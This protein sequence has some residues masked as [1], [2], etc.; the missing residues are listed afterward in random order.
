MNASATTAHRSFL[1]IVALP[2]CVATLVTAAIVGI[3][4]LWSTDQIDDNAAARQ[5][6]LVG[7]IIEDGIRGIA[8]DQESITV[9][10]DPVLKLRESP[11]DATWLDENLGSWMHSYFGHDHAYVLSPRNEA[12]F[13][14]VEG[15]VA[16]P[17][18]FG[19]IA[20]AV[21]PL[22]GELRK[23]IAGGVRIDYGSNVLTPGATDLRIVQGHPAIVSVKP[24]VPSSDRVSLAPGDESLHV[25]VRYLDG[26]FLT[27]LATDFQVEGVRYSAT[28]PTD[29][30]EA[31]HRLAGRDGSSL[32]AIVWTPYR[33][34]LAVFADMAPAMAAALFAI[35]LVMSLLLIGL[36]RSAN[37]LQASEAQAQHLALHDTLTGLPNRALFEDRLEQA[38]AKVRRGDTQVALHYLDLDRFKQVNDTLGHPAGDALIREVG[39][40]L[41]GVVRDCDTVARLGGDEFAII[42]TDVSSTASVEALCARIISALTAPFDLQGSQAFVGVSIGIATAPAAASRP[43]ELTR[44]ADI[45][46][47]HA[48]AGGRGR[49]VLFGEEMDATVQ[50]RRE[51]EQD[52][53]LAIASGDQLELC[54]QPL[55]DARSGAVIG[56]EALVRWDHPRLG[57]L[58]PA[59]FIPIAEE[60]GLIEALGDWVLRTACSAAVAWTDAIVAV[61]V[62]PVQ[63]RNPHFATRVLKILRETGLPPARLE[64]ELT[65]TALL[66]NTEAFKP[67]IGLLRAAG[68][69]IALDDFGTGYSSLS[70]LQ[71]IHVDRVKIDRSFV[72]RLGRHSNGEAIIQAIVDLAQATGLRITAEG[73]ETKEQMRFLT[74]VGCDN[75]QGFLF[76]RP[77]P[78]AEMDDVL[79]VRRRSEPAER[80]AA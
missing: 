73:I 33:P 23:A 77:M 19:A 49:Y 53:R 71:Q 26:S 9:W 62:S 10:D 72:Q 79:G 70:H 43:I 34:G 76:A 56:A 22:V 27:R 3:L 60:S 50:R 30:G 65:E 67:M 6:R 29:K 58:S 40:R 36:R 18:A 66:E 31:S 54:Y 32:G 47:Y 80:A 35:G 16:E 2:I 11:P 45:A 37:A 52:L 64:L 57:R 41:E 38:L 51:I 48:K 12:V 61:N 17:A 20:P 8:H 24:I 39:R 74:S 78:L 15:K 63:L 75:L 44:K 1:A 25:A 13:A 7:V 14:M 46:L 69:A 55:T 21:L 42:Q 59:A 28:G 4:L 5:Q 68:V